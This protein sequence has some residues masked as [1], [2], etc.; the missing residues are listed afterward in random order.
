MNTAPG[1]PGIG[2]TWTSSAKDLVTTVPGGRSRVWLTLGHGIGNEIYWPSNGEPQVRDV[3]FIVTAD[4]A[5]TEVKRA[6]RYD[7]SVPEPGVLLPTV[8]H[9]GDG[10]TLTCTW[11]IDPDRDVVL[12]EYRLDGRADGLFLIVAPHLGGGGPTNSAW[13][14]RGRMFAR[15]DASDAA[16]CIAATPGFEQCSTGF[17]GA[18]DGWQDIAAHG[19]MTWSYDSAPGGN[20]ALTAR[21]PFEG[22]VA[23]GF[24]PTATGAETLVRSS[25]AVGAEAIAG[26]FAHC[27]A[28]RTRRDRPRRA[29][30]PLGRA[31]HAGGRGAGVPRGPQL[32]GGDGC[33]SVD[34]VGQ[35]PQRSGW[36]S[37]RLGA[38]LRR[39][40]VRTP[41]AR[42]P[43]LGA[44]NTRLA[45]R[46]PAARRA[47][48]AERISRR[49]SVLDR[50]AARRDGAAGAARRRARRAGHRPTGRRDGARRRRVSS[51][52]TGRPVRRTA[53]RRTPARTGS[54][55]R[56]SSPP[57]SRRGP[58]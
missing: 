52:R 46:D 30:P 5:W 11:T 2:P 47:L 29:R 22:V 4:G 54:R 53:G 20:V 37:P 14:E 36:L 40:G 21:M 41:G 18:S 49:S 42:R 58:G 9:H 17:V 15:S 44:A 45:G 31:D 7:V 10:W 39:V 32:S 48:D 34:P 43:P 27:V 24:A 13:L 3:G 50:R 1:A 28:I 25:F 6:S 56:R 57:S 16:L 38:R 8:T 33:E 23:L 51:S 35:R 19:T 12:V 55:S 26:R